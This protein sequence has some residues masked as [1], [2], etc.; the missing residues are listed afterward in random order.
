MAFFLQKPIHI[1]IVEDGTDNYIII[2]EFVKLLGY[3]PIKATNG[4]DAIQI[5][6]DNSDIDLVLMDIKLPDINGFDL[7]IIIKELRPDIPIIIQSAYSSVNDMYLAQKAGCDDYITKPIE[8]D[9]L[10]RK[11]QKWLKN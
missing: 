5:I 4:R 9:L 11:L 10:R 2:S 6:K 3:F 1:L 8:I 7:T